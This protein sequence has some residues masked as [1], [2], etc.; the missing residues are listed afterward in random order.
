[1]LVARIPV[2]TLVS[3]LAALALAA[4]V[5]AALIAYETIRYRDARSW[6]RSH[7]GEFTIEEVSRIAAVTAGAPADPSGDR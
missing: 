3:A 2:S 5:S 4:M 7:R 1:V 6:I